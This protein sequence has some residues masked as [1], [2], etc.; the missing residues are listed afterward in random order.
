[1]E[2]LRLSNHEGWIDI[3]PFQ[4]AMIW[5]ACFFGVR[6]GRGQDF[7]QPQPAN[8]PPDTYGCLLYHAGMQRIGNPDMDGEPG[9]D[10][11]AP[12][13]RMEGAA[14]L[15]AD[16][17]AEG[18]FLSLLCGR[19][20]ADESGP[21]YLASH[22]LILRPGETEFDVITTIKNRAR[23]PLE[24][25]YRAHASFPFLPGARIL[26]PALWTSAHVKVRT[27]LAHSSPALRARLERL[28]AAPAAL[29]VL[30]PSLC[31]PEL[32]F[33]LTGVRTDAD[34]WAHLALRQERGDGFAFSY[35]PSEFPHLTRRL[36]YRPDEQAAAFALPSTSEPEG[37]DCAPHSGDPAGL[38]LGETR[39]FALRMGYLPPMMMTARARKI[40]TG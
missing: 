13:A 9:S 11:E 40:A 17:D 21:L 32:E 24:L 34:G 25:N 20:Q 10:G 18:P 7:A 30:D 35:R 8:G 4:G 26:Q 22:R 14:I 23:R 39:R 12:Y 5:D 1:V 37:F 6:L 16:Q 38:A 36:R 28:A 19:T 2:V 33:Y 31:D 27:D 3:L 29:E 15:V